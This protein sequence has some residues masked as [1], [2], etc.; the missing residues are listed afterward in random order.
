MKKIILMSLMTSVSLLFVGCAPHVGVAKAKHN[1]KPYWVDE[2]KCPSAEPSKE[3]TDTLLCKDS[4]GILNG[5][6]LT[7]M[8]N[9]QYRLYLYEQGIN[10]NKS[11]AAEELG[12]GLNQFAKG[13]NA[14][15]PQNCV[16]SYIGTRAYTNCY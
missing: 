16:T 4:N 2:S 6:T 1:G 7:P 9:E 12:N 15:R 3:N 5:L 10:S 14:N 13:M 8:D 11:S